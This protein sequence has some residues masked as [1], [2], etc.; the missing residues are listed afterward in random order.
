M[1]Q[2][3]IHNKLAF[4]QI[5]TLHKQRNVKQKVH[6]LQLSKFVLLFFSF[7][8]SGETMTINVR[9]FQ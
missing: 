4:V 2:I 6:T 5:R 9:K 8:F 7:N 1:Q 3:I